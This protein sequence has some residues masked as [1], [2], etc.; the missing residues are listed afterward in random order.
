MV[1]G[2]GPLGRSTAVL[3]ADGKYFLVAAAST[4]RLYSSVTGERVL[5]LNGHKAEVTA[6]V[7]DHASVEKVPV[8]SV[9][10]HALLLQYTSVSANLLRTSHVTQLLCLQ[11]YTASLDG[12]IKHWSHA[13]GQLLQSFIVG[14]PIQSMVRLHLQ[15]SHEQQ[16][17]N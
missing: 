5:S 13:S 10:W 16:Y 12:T 7:P 14:D 2:G 6:I 8:F 3:T 4:V 17:S 9:F 11:V 15:T 1:L